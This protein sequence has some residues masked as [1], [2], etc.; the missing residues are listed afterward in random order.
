M[1]IKKGDKLRSPADYKVHVNETINTEEYP[2]LALEPFHQK[3]QVLKLL[4]SLIYLM[5]VGKIHWMKK[6]ARCDMVTEN[7]TGGLFQVTRLQK[8]LK[9]AAAIF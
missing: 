4:R 6:I 2:Y 1:W 8:K 3:C 5:L 7:T 9:I